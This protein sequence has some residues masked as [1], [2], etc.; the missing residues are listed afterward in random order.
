MHANLNLLEQIQ[1]VGVSY[2][3]LMFAAWLVALKIKFLSLVDAVWALGIGVGGAAVLFFSGQNFTR[4]IFI[5]LLI[6]FWGLRLGLFLGSRLLRHFPSED[7][8]YQA[9]RN[10]WQHGWIWKTFL[11]FQFQAIAQTLFVLPFLLIAHDAEPFPKLAE[12][13]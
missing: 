3:L 13:L 6:A 9:L 7:S 2:S 4:S 12:M 1:V 8:R 11:F 10:T 5:G